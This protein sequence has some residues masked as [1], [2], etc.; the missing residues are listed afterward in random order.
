MEKEKTE[1][2]KAVETIEKKEE[3]KPNQKTIESSARVFDTKQ[4]EAIGNLALALS[5]A[6]G[7]MT[8]GKKGKEGYGYKY[9]ELGS[10][11]E[12]ARPA[13][14]E[15]EIAIVQSHEFI[16]KSK[17]TVVTHTHIIHS[18]GQWMKNS[19]EVPIT[20]MK[21]L[22]PAQ[23]IGVAS[24]YGRRYALQAICLIASEDDTDGTTKK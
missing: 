17:P 13:L 4:S 18:S 5:K 23:M 6:Q 21:Q 12:I 7:I 8:N 19:L 1:I 9:M 16:S 2:E 20:I 10:L 3:P 15:N 24:T 11:I 14:A 22:T